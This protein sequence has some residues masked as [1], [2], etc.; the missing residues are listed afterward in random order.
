[1][2]NDFFILVTYGRRLSMKLN[3]LRIIKVRYIHFENI[4]NFM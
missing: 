3:K 2:V 4:L 1:M